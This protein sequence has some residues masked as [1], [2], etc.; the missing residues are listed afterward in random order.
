[1][2][3]RDHTRPVNRRQ[4]GLLVYQN[5]YARAK[6]DGE[7]KTPYTIKLQLYLITKTD[8]SENNRP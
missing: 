6:G 1:M 7:S 8:T 3:V 4:K 5:R 2:Q